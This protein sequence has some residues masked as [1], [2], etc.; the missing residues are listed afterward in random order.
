MAGKKK[1]GWWDETLKAKSEGETQ[2]LTISSG[3]V[4][5]EKIGDQDMEGSA[6]TVLS[7]LL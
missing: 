7:Y 6:R 2:R 4:Q 3:V 5:E 1:V